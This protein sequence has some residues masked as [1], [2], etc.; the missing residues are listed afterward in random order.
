MVCPIPSGDHEK[1][2]GIT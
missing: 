1:P 2:Q